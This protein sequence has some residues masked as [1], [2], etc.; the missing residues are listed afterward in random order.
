[1]I[2]CNDISQVNLKILRKDINAVLQNPFVL[3]TDTI[4]QN[5]DPKGLFSDETLEKVLN[6]AAL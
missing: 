2:D 5:L 1:M 4:R 6:D 3:V